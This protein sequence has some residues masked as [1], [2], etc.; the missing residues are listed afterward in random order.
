[1]PQTVDHFTGAYAFLASDYWADVLFEEQLYPTVEH[2]SQ[3]AK[4][5][6]VVQRERIR[7]APTPQQARRLGQRLRLRADWKTFRLPLMVTLLQQKFN[8]LIH[9]QLAQALLATEERLLLAG[10][11]YCGPFWGV[12]LETGAGENWL[13]RLLMQLRTE[14]TVRQV[15]LPAPQLKGQ[16]R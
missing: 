14:L 7:R 2:A 13:G 11:P 8:P 10:Y 4:T 15:Y 1:M 12:D 3:A 5:K 16:D 6:S 9:P